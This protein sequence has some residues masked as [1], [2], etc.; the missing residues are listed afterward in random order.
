MDGSVPVFNF[1]VLNDSVLCMSFVVC[2]DKY[3]AAKSEYRELFKDTREI[4]HTEDD[5]T[6]RTM[7]YKTNVEREKEEEVRNENINSNLNL[8]NK[9]KHDERMNSL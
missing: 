9:K 7:Y 8:D 4:Q 3:T 5:Y 1:N 6:L 2:N